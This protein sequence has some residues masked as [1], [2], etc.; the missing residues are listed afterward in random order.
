MELDKAFQLAV[1]FAWEDLAQAS[2][3]RSVRVEYQRKPG[4]SLIE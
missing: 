4:T 3:E 1:I 2:Q